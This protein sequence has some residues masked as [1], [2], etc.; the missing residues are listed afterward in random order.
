MP[1][2]GSGRK[3]GR[4]RPEVTGSGGLIG[5]GARGGRE[6]AG[7]LIPQWLGVGE[8]GQEWLEVGQNRW[9]S[10]HG[11]LLHHLRFLPRSCR[12]QTFDDILSTGS[13]TVPSVSANPIPVMQCLS[14]LS[15]NLDPGSFL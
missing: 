12:P 15:Q 10:I 5:V 13:V 2:G 1:V 3:W 6:I 14:I 9:D 11:R 7:R 4:E 8:S